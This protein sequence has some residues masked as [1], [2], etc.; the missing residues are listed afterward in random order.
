[1]IEV[2]RAIRPHPGIQLKHGHGTNDNQKNASWDT[3]GIG[4]TLT[5]LRHLTSIGYGI[6][7][8]TRNKVTE[9]ARVLLG[10]A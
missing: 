9:T 7:L 1:M 3:K 6:D 5:L 10:I 2:L 8:S 4:I